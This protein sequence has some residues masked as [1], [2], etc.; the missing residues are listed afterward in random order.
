MTDTAP[1]N[2]LLVDDEDDVLEVSRMVLEDLTFEDRPL[3]ILTSRSAREARELFELHDDIALAF[4]DVV[5]ETEHAGLDLVKYVREQLRNDRTRLILRTGNPGAAPERDVVRYLEIDDYKEKTELTA[6]RLGTAVLTSLRSYRNLLSRLHFQEGLELVIG[7]ATPVRGPGRLADRLDD[8]VAQCARIMDFVLGPGRAHGLVLQHG[9][10]GLRAIGGFGRHAGQNDSDAAR[11]LLRVL[12]EEA[13]AG[14]TP[15]GPAQRTAHGLLLTHESHPRE[16]F[17]L[18]IAD[19]PALPG[20]ASK[21]LQLFLGQCSGVLSSVLLQQEVIDAQTEV[22]HRLCE[23]VESRSKET[24]SHIR[25]IAKYAAALGRL[26][27]L[28]EQQVLLLEAASPLHDIGKVSIPDHILHKPGKLDPQE[29]ELM[30][31]HAALGYTLLSHPNLAV[32]QAG[33]EIA[34]SHHEKWD[35]SGYPRGLAGEDIPLPGRIVALVDVFDALLSRRAYKEPWPIESV[36]EEMKSLRGRH[37]DPRLTDLLLD[38]S[39]LFHQIFV[40]HPDHAGDGAP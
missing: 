5:M 10:A 6:D 3:N 18:W 17:H 22:L 4:V 8:F 14:T 7:A 30:K 20:D 33:A 34:R 25:R 16:S 15:A 21:I 23:A 31:T 13:F 24:G 29:W 36:I 11:R 32:M 26:A 27:G 2:I 28:D 12:A 9:P 19:V 38:H 1:W 40:D 35:G 39:E 37:F